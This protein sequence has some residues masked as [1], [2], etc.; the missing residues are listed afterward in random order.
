MPATR[1]LI[2]LVTL[3]SASGAGAQEVRYSYDRNGE[4]A[5]V[6]YNGGGSISYTYDAAFSP[7]PPQ[8]ARS[9]PSHRPALRQAG[10]SRPD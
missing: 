8:A 3:A 1:G 5:K 10:Q 6:E 7:G 4:V 2:L 9:P